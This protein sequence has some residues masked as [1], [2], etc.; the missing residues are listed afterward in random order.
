[1]ENG[2]PA[3]QVSTEPSVEERL[4]IANTMIR[5]VQEQVMDMS[6][7]A[8]NARAQMAQVQLQLNKK[9]QE[10]IDLSLKVTQLEEEMKTF[11]PATKPSKSAP[12]PEPEE[13]AAKK[14]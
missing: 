5:E 7:R 2:T 1:M 12:A 8:V 6:T 10:V 9:T 4:Q 13:A 3:P 11:R 14:H